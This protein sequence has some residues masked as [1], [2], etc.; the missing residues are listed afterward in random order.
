MAK[1]IRSLMRGR[2]Q[3]SY[4]RNLENLR[5]QVT[6]LFDYY[7]TCKCQEAEDG[8]HECVVPAIQEVHTWYMH[9]PDSKWMME[10]VYSAI[11]RILEQKQNP[12]KQTNIGFGQ[13]HVLQ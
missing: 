11:Q 7:G 8:E 12:R 10:W 9:D 4:R 2:T 1:R 3:I 13:W 6:N 5:T